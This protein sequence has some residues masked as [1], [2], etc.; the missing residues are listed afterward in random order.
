MMICLLICMLS[1]SIYPLL[2]SLFHQHKLVLLHDE[3]LGSL[4]T[5]CF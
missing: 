5:R 4:L 3:F 1:C 2:I